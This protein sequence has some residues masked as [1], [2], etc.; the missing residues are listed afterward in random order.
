M[1]QLMRSTRRGFFEVAAGAAALYQ[2]KAASAVNPFQ[3][4]A[5]AA[6]AKARLREFTGRGADPDAAAQI[7]GRLTSLDAEPWVA[8]WTKLAVP[9]E[10]QGAE[11]ESQGKLEQANNAYQMAATYYGIAKFPVIN[12]P[13]KQ[14]AY[15]KVVENYFEGRTFPGSTHGERSHPVRR[16]TDYRLS[17]QAEGC[18]A[19]ANC[20]RYRW[21]GRL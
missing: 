18:R 17:A 5:Y 11:L 16:Q 15:R 14:A 9:F 1:L 21:R 2:L 12:H 4:P 6:G 7:F 3:D 8:E 20:D 13:A 10:H 19:A